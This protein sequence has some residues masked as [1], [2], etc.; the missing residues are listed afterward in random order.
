MGQKQ[1]LTVLFLLLVASASGQILRYR[2]GASSGMFLSETGADEIRHPQAS[3]LEYPSATE[4]SPTLKLGADF[5]IM[6]P[7]TSQLEV[8]LEFEYGN[9]SGRTETSPLYNFYFFD[10]INPLPNDYFYPSEPVMY[11]TKQLSILGT[12]RLY[13]LPPREKLNIFA[14]V[15]GGVSFIGTD[16]KFVNEVDNV[17]YNV[18]VLYTQGTKSNPSPK[19]K[20]LQAGAGF[21][22]TYKFS[23][24]MA[25]YLEFTG[26]FINSDIVNGVPNFDYLPN[27]GKQ[28]RLAEGVGSLTGQISVGLVYSAVGDSRLN[29]GN[30][31][32]SKRIT[33]KKTWMR[34][35]SH[36][37]GKSKKR[38]R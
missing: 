29:R 37:F 31:T 8:G 26:S 38:R 7:L 33:K 36:P 10:W 21:G 35:K 18:G 14:K 9:L 6:A 19:D 15:F 5:E 20:A 13:F 28:F 16:F 11:D 30:Y 23:D 34:K 27:A 25:F 32:K 2:L 22:S 3:I 17:S 4:L 1:I 24:V 12:T